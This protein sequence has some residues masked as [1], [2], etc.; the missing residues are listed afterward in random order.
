MSLD[1]L[2]NINW[3]DILI[4][5]ISIRIIYIGTKNGFIVEFFKWIGVL[6]SIFITFHYYSN[7]AKIL[8]SRLPISGSIAQSLCF[9]LLWSLVFLMFKL[10]REGMMLMLKIQA[11]SLLDKWGGLLVS[12]LRSI[13]IGSLV[14]VF[15]QV[16]GVEYITKNVRKSFLNDYLFDIAPKVYEVSYDGFVD[17]FF[18]SEKLNL[19]VFKLKTVDLKDSSHPKSE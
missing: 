9:V 12:I 3:V 16:L 6:F 5:A 15:L 4:G 18:P 8:Q 14:L 11:H 13:L 17:K 1:I 10:I 19:A 7:L 2:K